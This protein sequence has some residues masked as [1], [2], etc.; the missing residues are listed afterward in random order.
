MRNF[1]KFSILLLLVMLVPFSVFAQAS[2]EATAIEVGDTVEGELTESQGV[3][4]YTL[5]LDERAALQITMLAPD[6][7]A[8]L[9]LLDEDGEEIATD[10]DSAGSLNA[11]LSVTLSAGTYTIAAQSYGY[12]RVERATAGD[13]TL[14]LEE[15][16]INQ[17][18]Y[19]QTIEG[20]LTATQTEAHYVFSGQAG[21]VII[22]SQDSADFDSYL[23]L[24]LNGS[25][26]T[27]N[28][29]GGEG[30][31]SKIGPYVLPTT[32]EYTIIAT[33]YTR[34]STGDYTLSLLPIELIEIEKDEPVEASFTR[35]NQTL[36]L[37]FEAEIGDILDILV[38]GEFEVNLSVKDS[39]EYIVAET[40]NTNSL[41]AIV[42]DTQGTHLL[43]INPA[44]GTE[45]GEFSV[46]L[47]DTILP[48]LNES[49]QIFELGANSYQQLVT[50][51][52]KAGDS[53]RLI[54]N[55]LDG[56]AASPSIY[57]AQDGTSF[58][59][60]NTSGVSRISADFTATSTGTLLITISEYSYE[61]REIEVIAEA[62]GT[63]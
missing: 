63:E 16:Q 15:F 56:E 9:V 42:I 27:R 57:I 10:D 41:N 30:L 18:E 5:E 4:F 22:I 8:Y 36:Y 21:D 25:E 59:S 61:L 44:S 3:A 29:D 37:S 62:L 54:V 52:V 31:N 45:I 40:T 20:T 32:G 7:D 58:I 38:D 2:E 60:Q 43:E 28:D 33:S 24:E 23:I 46:Q 11:Q 26:V 1:R 35:T 13:F 34:S 14:T 19:T 55:V 6:F 17:I 47:T 51:D 12:Y 50:L 48:S 53:Y 49:P 39:N